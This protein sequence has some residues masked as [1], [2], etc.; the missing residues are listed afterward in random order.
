MNADGSNPVQLTDS[1]GPDGVAG[2]VAGRHAHRV[3]VGPR[4]LRLLGRARLPD[5][6]RHRAPPRHLGRERG[7]DRAHT[8]HAGVRP[9][10]D[11]VPGREVPARVR[12]RPLRHPARRHGSRLARHP[13]DAARRPLPGPDLDPL[14][15]EHCAT[16]LN[17]LEVRPPTGISESSCEDS[18]CETAGRRPGTTQG[19]GQDF[20]ALFSGL[21]RG[22]RRSPGR[23]PQRVRRSVAR[24][25]L[26]MHVERKATRTDS[27]FSKRQCCSRVPQVA[28][29]E[30][31]EA[32]RSCWL[33]PDE[34]VEGGSAGSA[35]PSVR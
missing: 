10:R 28:K 34:P 11:L 2:L 19:Q 22:D 17:S 32:S 7:W 15:S 20:G 6:G 8:R 1:P 3:R 16:V 21:P 31:F 26:S 25:W 18:S 35:P 9:V 27:S 12:L 33:G 30:A 23:S 13:G 24:S 14:R 29:R 5:H 4:R